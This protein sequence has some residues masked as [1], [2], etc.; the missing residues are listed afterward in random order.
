MVS[1]IMLWVDGVGGCIYQILFLEETF[2]ALP[3]WADTL[4]ALPQDTRPTTTWF[5]AIALLRTDGERDKFNNFAFL[6]LQTIIMTTTTM[7]MT[8]EGDED[9][10]SDPFV[11]IQ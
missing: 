6:I 1:A 3:R 8:G 7:T 2:N 5:Y 10:V 4:P 9:K 11:F